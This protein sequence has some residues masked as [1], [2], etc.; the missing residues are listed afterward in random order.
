MTG[1]A[2]QANSF[3]NKMDQWINWAGFKL[4]NICVYGAFAIYDAFCMCAF[5]NPSHACICLKC[6]ILLLPH[7]R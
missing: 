5:S 1:I 7:Y 2:I 4:T 3:S 6:F